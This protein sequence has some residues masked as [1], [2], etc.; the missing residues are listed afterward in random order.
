MLQVRHELCILQMKCCNSRH[1]LVYSS[2]N[3]DFNSIYHCTLEPFFSAFFLKLLNI[4]GNKYL[5]R[6]IGRVIKAG[7][8]LL[9]LLHLSKVKGT[10]VRKWEKVW[11]LGG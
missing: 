2:R 1:F 8:V 10:L 7:N 6:E 9:G 3:K 4:N 5:Q 11:S